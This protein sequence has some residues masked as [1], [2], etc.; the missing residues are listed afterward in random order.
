MEEFVRGKK[1]CNENKKCNFRYRKY[2]IVFQ[3]KMKRTLIG[4]NGKSVYML[5]SFL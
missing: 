2:I 4:E 1:V 3:L 5:Q